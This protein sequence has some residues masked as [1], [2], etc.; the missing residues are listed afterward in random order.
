MSMMS[1]RRS[2]LA[3]MIMSSI[4]SISWALYLQHTP[5]SGVVD[6]KTV[7]LGARCLVEHRD[8]YNESQVQQIFEAE[9]GVV[10]SD[11]VERLKFQRALM[12]SVYLPS[13]LLCLA[14][15]AMLGWAT[16]YALWT[17]LTILLLTLAACLMWQVAAD[18]APVVSACLLGFMLANTEVL[19]AFGNAAGVAIGFCVIAVWCF[20]KQRFL[21]TGVICFAIS[22]A[23]KPHDAALVW[24]YF[25]LAGGIYRKR[26]IQIALAVLVLSLPAIVW[27]FNVSPNWMREM[28]SNLELVSVRGGS[29]DPG[30]TGISNGTGGEIID[31]QSAISIFRDDPLT[32]NSVTYILCAPLIVAWMFITLRGSSTS[33]RAWLALAAMAALSMLPIYH[34]PYDAKLL[35]LAVPACAMLWVERGY[36]WRRWIAL[37][38]TS[39]AILLSSDIPFTIIVALGKGLPRCPT[40]ISKQILVVAATRSIPLVLLAMSVF[41]VWVYR[42]ESPQL[43]K[44]RAALPEEL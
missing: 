40:S 15:I 5:H 3:L 37:L 13:A 36:R 24:L 6:F 29:S 2:G 38:T 42:R 26:A 18:Y 11:P 8:P 22:L 9:G 21:R 35:M 23:L 20:L 28:H 27:A 44:S 32:Y 39:S 43:R 41:Y 31:L 12:T 17:I 1:A 4:L 33:V 25:L 34:R 16:A 10:P 7:Y 30:P 14:P 19:F